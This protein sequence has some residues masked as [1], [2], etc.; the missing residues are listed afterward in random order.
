M[1]GKAFLG[2]LTAA[3]SAAAL[4]A[5]GASEPT[6]YTPEVRENFVSACIDGANERTGGNADQGQIERICGCMYDELKTRMTFEEFKA[7]DEALR[8]GEQVSGK[9]TSTLQAAASASA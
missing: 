9:F 4:A 1:A 6:T 3:A 2:F 8:E 7:A 5:C